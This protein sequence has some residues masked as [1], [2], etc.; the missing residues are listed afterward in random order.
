M[1]AHQLG[2]HEDHTNEKAA[3]M[4]RMGELGVLA[5]YG[6]ERTTR[7]WEQFGSD[8]EKAAEW[9]KSGIQVSWDKAKDKVHDVKEMS[10]EKLHEAKEKSKEKLDEAKEQATEKTESLKQ[11]AENVPQEGKNAFMR[12]MTDLGYIVKYGAHKCN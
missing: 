2:P 9:I 1:P 8:V 12:K 11:D 4:K 10:K 5:E 3:F 6:F 7:A